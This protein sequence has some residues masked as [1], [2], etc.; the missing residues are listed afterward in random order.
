MSLQPDHPPIPE[1]AIPV[2]S[3]PKVVI[4]GSA[5]LADG[6]SPLE[7]VLAVVDTL[8]AGEGLIVRAPFDPTP[9]RGLLEQMGLRTA[10]AP[11]TDGHWRAFI[12]RP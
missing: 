7:D 9:L 5:I 2:L 11:W 10:A 4:D 3:A 12:L 1:W 6:G 8:R